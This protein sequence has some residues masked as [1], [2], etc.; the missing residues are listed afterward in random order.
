MRTS[1]ITDTTVTALLVVDDVRVREAMSDLLAAAVGFRLVAAVADPA[2]AVQHAARHAPAIGIVDLWS[3]ADQV[4][5]GLNVVTALSRQG[6]PVL[7]LTPRERVG[8][9]A[10]DAGAVAFVDKG[11]GPDQVLEA[12]RAVAGVPDA[13][14][15]SQAG[16]A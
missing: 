1:P 3:T 12:A 2:E 4:P 11:C 14:P 9:L 13:G 16:L 15:E 10:L 8:A 5:R 7:A 6:V